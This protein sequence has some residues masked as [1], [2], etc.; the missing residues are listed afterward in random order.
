MSMIVD[1]VET[2]VTFPVQVRGH[3]EREN[4]P[5]KNPQVLTVKL[6]SQKYHQHHH[7]HYLKGSLSRQRHLWHVCWLCL[8]FSINIHFL[9]SFAVASR[10]FNFLIYLLAHFS[11]SLLS[12]LFFSLSFN[13]F[14]GFHHTISHDH[15]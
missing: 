14:I 4:Q 10:F 15:M 5:Q 7:L 9:L 11:L 3:L 13:S 12:L 6:L 2:T 8:F 1:S